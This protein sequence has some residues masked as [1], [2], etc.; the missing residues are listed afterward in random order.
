M[1]ETEIK[2]VDS[3]L[4]AEVIDGRIVISIGVET[5]KYCHNRLE[6]GFEPRKG[7]GSGFLITDATGFARDIVSRLKKEREDGSTILTDLL[8]KATEEAAED[9]SQHVEE[10][11]GWFCGQCDK[12]M[13]DSNKGY[14][15]TD[16]ICYC[17]LE[18]AE[19][20]DANR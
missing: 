2:S 14:V 1:N 19:E 7:Y 10:R 15:H 17:S 20:R 9:G 13:P 6:E 18:C 8:D 5:L 12:G 16:G 11:F 3:P 4:K